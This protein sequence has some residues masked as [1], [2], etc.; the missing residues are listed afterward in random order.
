MYHT[1]PAYY[2]SYWPQAW[3]VDFWDGMGRDYGLTEEMMACPTRPLWQRV[4]FPPETNPGNL[5]GPVYYSSYSYMGNPEGGYGVATWWK[6]INS[7]AQSGQS[8]SDAY[9]A[10]DFIR[11]PRDVWFPPGWYETNHT[12]GLT[13]FGYTNDR[14]LFKGA[15]LLHLGLN[16]EWKDSGEYPEL[17]IN[18]PD[19]P[20]SPCYI[21]NYAPYN[22]AVYW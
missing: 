13:P 17:L 7:V 1:N 4:Y 3:K 19:L 11:V 5:W 22:C 20:T 16:V 8:S 2:V 18:D 6:D 9:L 10:A 21:L 12:T 14:S 15:N